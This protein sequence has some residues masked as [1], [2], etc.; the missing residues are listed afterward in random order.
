MMI[1]KYTHKLKNEGTFCTNHYLMS[2]NK[3]VELL[4]CLIFVHILGLTMS[5]DLQC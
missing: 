3:E 4:D 1:T 5:F 2:K